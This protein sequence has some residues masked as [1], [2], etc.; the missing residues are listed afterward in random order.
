VTDSTSKK[1]IFE[2]SLQ[3][4]VGH[5]HCHH[6]RTASTHCGTT[7]DLRNP[8]RTF[9]WMVKMASFHMVTTVWW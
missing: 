6:Q 2:L 4:R 5:H 9:H 3:R 8:W 7:M 1:V